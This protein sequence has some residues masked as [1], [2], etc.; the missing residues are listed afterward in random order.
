V[1]TIR[2][3]G[4]RGEGKTTT[5]ARIVAYLRSLGLEVHYRGS[6]ERQEDLIEDIIRC[7][8]QLRMDEPRQF[9]VID[10]DEVDATTR[11]DPPGVRRLRDVLTGVEELVKVN[12]PAW[13]GFS[14]DEVRRAR[15]SGESDTPT[16]VKG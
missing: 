5:A 3:D 14:P 11:A 10:R 9:E 15:E 1:I 7:G 16:V 13:L 12:D 8:G 4:P 2:V 6:S